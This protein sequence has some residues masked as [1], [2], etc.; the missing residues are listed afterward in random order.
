MIGV[1]LNV[2]GKPVQHVLWRI[3]VEAV[4]RSGGAALGHVAVNEGANAIKRMASGSRTQQEG[5]AR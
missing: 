5:G 4:I 2:A 3:F 1:L